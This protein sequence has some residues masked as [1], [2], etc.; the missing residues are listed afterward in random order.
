MSD[1]S[2]KSTV[3][4]KKRDRKAEEERGSVAGSF[5][6]QGHNEMT[7]HNNN[8]NDP[9]EENLRITNNIIKLQQELKALEG[10]ER[11]GGLSEM[12]GSVS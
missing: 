10:R 7:F 3:L 12:Q 5:Q 9:Q 4:L 1:C 11:L 2:R 8:I 6:K